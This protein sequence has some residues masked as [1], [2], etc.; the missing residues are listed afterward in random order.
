MVD[1]DLIIIGAGGHAGVIIDACERQGE[2]GIAGLIDDTKPVDS[3]VH[4]YRVIGGIKSL[5]DRTETYRNK[6]HFFIDIGDNYKRLGIYN[7]LHELKLKYT[8]IIHPSSK[9]GRYVFMETGIC[10]MAGAIVQPGCRIEKQ[11][12][13]NTNSSVDHDSLISE[14]ASLAPSSA[15]AGNVRIGER[16]A[17]CMGAMIL[18]GVIVGNNTIIGSGSI[19]TTD[20]GDNIV[21]YGVPCKEVRKREEGGTAL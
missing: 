6:H 8:N 17:V 14:F 20:Q 18:N 13:L 16:T 4:G 21:A 3:Y 19:V 7:R 15:T 12:I 1:N 2:F 5:F 10:I 9:I 11:V